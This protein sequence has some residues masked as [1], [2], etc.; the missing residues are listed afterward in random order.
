M[1]ISVFNGAFGV[2]G[3]LFL[4]FQQASALSGGVLSREI[5][6]VSYAILIGCMRIASFFVWP[7]RSFLPMTETGE[8]REIRKDTSGHESKLEAAETEIEQK[9]RRLSDLQ[10]KDFWGKLLSMPWWANAVFTLVNIFGI[11]YYTSTGPDQLLRMGD[12]APW[13]SRSLA[14]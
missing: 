14:G 8:I 12:Y 4:V 1:L 6:F 3:L 5:L 10:A 13:A 7:V 2:S 11:Q 9:K